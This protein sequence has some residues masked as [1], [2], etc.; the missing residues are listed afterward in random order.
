VSGRY[1]SGCDGPRPRAVRVTIS[2]PAT[3][4]WPHGGPD[5]A[6]RDQTGRPGAGQPQ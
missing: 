2:A 3:S 1:E 4:V 6:G 5:R